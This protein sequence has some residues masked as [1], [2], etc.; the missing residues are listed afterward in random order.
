MLSNILLDRKNDYAQKY[1]E[2]VISRHDILLE[3]LLPSGSY[4][5]LY[6]YTHLINGFALHTSSEEVCFYEF[7]ETINGSSSDYA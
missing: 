7:E 4:T 1:K 3:S 2:K 5:K 6:S